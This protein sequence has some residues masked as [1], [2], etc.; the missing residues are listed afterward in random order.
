[1]KAAVSS[2]RGGGEAG[3]GGRC[4]MTRSQRGR[5]SGTRLFQK[6]TEENVSYVESGEGK[7][8]ETE[9]GRRQRDRVPEGV[10]RGAGPP[11]LW[12]DRADPGDRGL[13]GW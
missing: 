7:G 10:G 4:G 6:R 1:M 3:E 11:W 9:A 2:V 5:W 8:M 13:Q 12:R